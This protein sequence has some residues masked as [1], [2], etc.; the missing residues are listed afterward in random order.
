MAMIVN[1]TNKTVCSVAATPPLLMTT[2]PS[3]PSESSTMK[4][5][6]GPEISKARSQILDGDVEFV[7]SQNVG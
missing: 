5:R 7:S 1:V 3:S 2:S 6:P 4:D